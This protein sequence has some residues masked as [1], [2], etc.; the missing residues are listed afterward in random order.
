MSDRENRGWGMGSSYCCEVWNRTRILRLSINRSRL[1]AIL[2]TLNYLQLTCYSIIQWH[3]FHIY[4]QRL[5]QRHQV[6]FYLKTAYSM[7]YNEQ[8]TSDANMSGYST[9]MS[10][11]IS[12]E[13]Q[14][15][16][17]PATDNYG[18][19]ASIDAPSTSKELVND[20][21]MDPRTS[22]RWRGKTLE[23]I[24]LSSKELQRQLQ[25]YNVYLSSSVDEDV[26]MDGCELSFQAKLDEAIEFRDLFANY[27]QK[28]KS[29]ER[30]HCCSI[31]PIY[32]VKQ[33]INE[34]EDLVMTVIRKSKRK[35]SD[36]TTEL[37][38]PTKRSRFSL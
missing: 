12:M 27:L 34:M 10:T 1:S 7:A 5:H 24:I 26:V 23:Q 6:Q 36:I 19:R 4:S 11:P 30:E 2:S 17:S 20:I 29:L 25:E 15:S 31:N 21:Q 9:S 3:C 8:W 14:D 18:Y 28:N 37:L 33:I 13:S 22:S 38:H 35:G 32:E 16:L